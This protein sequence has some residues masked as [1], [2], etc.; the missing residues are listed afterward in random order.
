MSTAY[1]KKK[2]RTP[3]AKIA[4]HTYNRLKQSQARAEKLGC[5]ADNVQPAHWK[6]IMDLYDRMCGYCGQP[7]D[8]KGRLT[9]DHLHPLIQGGEHSTLNLVPAC[10]RCNL[11]KGGKTLLQ[12]MVTR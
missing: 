3:G 6:A 9:V 8:D 1:K 2:R 11:S 10:L 4:R 12:W 5:R 7:A